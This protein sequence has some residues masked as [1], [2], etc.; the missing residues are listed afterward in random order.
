VTKEELKAQA[1]KVGPL[2][3][4]DNFT[5][6]Q[7]AEEILY[8]LRPLSDDAVKAQMKSS[9]PEVQA[10]AH[11]VAQRSGLLKVEEKV[12]PPTILRHGVDDLRGRQPADP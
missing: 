8:L 12:K 11:K 9:D 1:E 10:R 5:K 3:G 7:A 4:D 6:R 2:L